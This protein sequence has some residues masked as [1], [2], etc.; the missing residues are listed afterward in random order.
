MI[1]F[2]ICG[3]GSSQQTIR[4]A[5]FWP[6]VSV[7][8]ALCLTFCTN[9][10]AQAQIDSTAFTPNDPEFQLG[11]QYSLPLINAPQAWSYTAGDPRIAVALIDTGIDYNHPELADHIHPDGRTFFLSGS[12]QDE[13]GHGT[14]TAGIIAATTHN[15]QGIA[16]I[17]PNVQ[18]LPIKVSPGFAHVNQQGKRHTRVA[19]SMEAVEYNFQEPIRY[20]AHPDRNGTKVI[21]I[22]FASSIEDPQE[23]E[24]I[25]DALEQGV[26]VVAAAGNSAK[27]VPLYPAAYDCV[28]GVGA[29]NSQA[30]RA[31]FSTY[32]L[33]VD[34]VA[35]GSSILSTTL[36]DVSGGYAYVHG[37][38]FASPHVSGLAAMIFSIR[39]DL[40]AWDVRDI[41]MR[42]AQDL[43][44]PGFDKEYGYGLIDAQAALELAKLWVAGSGHQLD[45]CTGE[46]YRIYG[47]LY[48]DSNQNGE[49]DAE[50]ATFSEPYTNTTTYIELYAQNGTQ[51]VDRTFP[52]HNG[53]FTFDVRYA[54][55]E[56]PYILKLQN[57]TMTHPLYFA[58]NFSGPN[59]IDMLALQNQTIKLQGTFFVDSN[60]DGL[61][62]RNELA[63]EYWG[64]RP[65]KV[66]LYG[67]DPTTPL[68][69]ATANEQGNFL[70]YVQ[71]PIATITYTL[72]SVNTPETPQLVRAYPIEVSPTTSNSIEIVVG[73]D[74]NTV[75]VEGQNGSPN[76]TPVDLRIVSQPDT[77]DTVQ[78]IVLQWQNPLSLRTDSIYEI[79][80]ASHA[81]GPY[82]PVATTTT[83]QMTSYTLYDFPAGTH[84]FVIRARTS[85]G[86]HP[87]F[88]SGYS[89]EV[90][91]TISG[92]NQHQLFLPII[93]N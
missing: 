14:Q 55:H 79:A 91:V 22:N 34:V 85:D 87:E 39:P 69:I 56:A 74:R 62:T 52:N 89:N 83:S 57:S 78:A 30:Q 27:D 84:Y 5:R 44:T 24:A 73:V 93:S 65:A 67:I 15:N 23:G 82:Q 3:N 63:Y 81:G 7:I 35:P 61:Q 32:G 36:A 86:S 53:I 40:T 16:G 12:P 47:S 76:S 70:F 77:D 58:A 90:V 75:P 4:F 37:T 20:A 71:P 2:S 31:G 41:I 1:E 8:A 46:R 64:E 18:I 10:I 33:G 59:D 80:A 68:A 21:N 72:R 60:N 6:I 48:F 45:Q 17:A 88:W 19:T 26:V 28:L 54:P 51:L 13:D 92:T 43:G 25:Y 38:S 50:E 11:N 29:V 9:T 66:A 49:R 42:S